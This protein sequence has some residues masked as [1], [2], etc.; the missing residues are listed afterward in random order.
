MSSEFSLTTFN[1]KGKL[2]Q[3]E[4]ALKAVEN[5]ETSIGIRYKNGIVLIVEKNIKSP[6]IDENSV[7]KI[8]HIAE[9]VGATYSGLSGDFRILLQFARKQSMKHTLTYEEP[10]LMGSIA[11]ETGKVFQEFTQGGSVRPFGI[12]IL[13][14]GIDCDGPQ[15]FQLDP[16]G[17]YHEWKAT[18]IGKNG[19][20]AKLFLEKRYKDDLDRDDAIQIG[21]LAMKEGFEGILNNR[22]IEI[23]YIETSDKKFKVINQREIADILSFISD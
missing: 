8:Q 4:Y 15:L 2:K 14:A 12:S 23:G 18:A 21:L 6:L 10:I 11:R 16:S 5:G 17:V 13:M 22:N 7:R 9:H 20:N 3:I 19:S 1:S